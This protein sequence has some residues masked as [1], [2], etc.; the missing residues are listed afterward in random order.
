VLDRYDEAFD[1]Q[2]TL[3]MDELHAPLAPPA[4]PAK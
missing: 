2:F 1:Q 3:R 4:T